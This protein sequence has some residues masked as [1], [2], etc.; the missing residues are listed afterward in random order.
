MNSE[1]CGWYVI[2]FMYFM[3]NS[4]EKKID[5]IYK[6][7]MDLFNKKNLLKNDDILYKFFKIIIF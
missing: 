4:K 7:F 2:A 6:N 5:I 3:Q 1:L